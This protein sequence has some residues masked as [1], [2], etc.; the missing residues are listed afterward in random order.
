MASRFPSPVEDVSPLAQP[1]RFEFSQRTAPNRFLKAAMTEK[2]SSWDPQNKEARGIPSTAIHNLYQ[3]WG[4]GELGHILT[5]NIML[6]Y[7][8]LEAA[9]NLII[10][11]DDPFEGPRFDAFAKL[12]SLAKAHGSLITG[13][14][15]HPGRQVDRRIQP[16]PVSASDV[17]LQGKVLGLEFAKP[18]PASQE[19]INEIVRSFT[20]AAQYLQRA[21]FDGIELQGAH[22]YLLSQFLS[23]TTNLRTDAYGG[24]LRNRA[25]LIMEIAQCIR[26]NTPSDF[27][28]GIKINSVEF[29][30]G[31]LTVE[32]A[33]ELC[34]ML[35]EATFDFVELSGGT[36]QAMAFKHERESTRKREA[37]FLEFADMIVPALSKTKTYITGG[38][39]TLRGMLEALKTVDG[40]GL[41]RVVAQEFSL[42][43][44][45]LNGT[46]TGAIDRKV[47]QNDFALTNI[48]AGSQMRQVGK[49]QEPI[50][51]SLEQNVQVFVKAMTSWAQRM[52]DDA[53]TMKLFGYVDLDL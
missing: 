42:A 20:F 10:P 16:D 3:R 47:N 13:Q 6:A 32:E 35:E 25:R 1:L 26:A 33:R 8:Q 40:V 39:R 9:G 36:Y 17:Q 37:F 22:G 7:D 38:F 2:L 12:A 29:Q 11:T 24:S 53:E 14:V 18:H 31:G 19:E 46:I 4:E 30:S 45:M 51:M 5:G 43:K 50:D 27:I 49:G 15:T 23:R 48:I 52:A 21:G 41:G 44:D 34:Q 28:L